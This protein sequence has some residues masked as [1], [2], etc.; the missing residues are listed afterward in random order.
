MTDRIDEML[1]T[2]RRIERLLTRFELD[3]AARLHAIDYGTTIAELCNSFQAQMHGLVDQPTDQ[4]RTQS[5]TIGV[6]V[7]RTT[8]H[9]R[10]E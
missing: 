8:G 7:S 9:S 4:H 6:S 1:E 3:A 10:G 2:L 5:R